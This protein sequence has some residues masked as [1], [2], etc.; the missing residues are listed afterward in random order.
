MIRE[1]SVKPKAS[2]DKAKRAFVFC[3]IAAALC[4][5]LSVFIDLYHGVVSLV[6]MAFLVGGVTIYT[7]YLAVVFIYEITFDSEGTPLFVV[8]QTIGKRHTTL[9]RIGLNEIIRVEKQDRKTRKAHTTPGGFRKYVY[10]PSLDPDTI[11][12]LKTVSRYEKS[13][14][15]IEVSD[16]YASLIERYAAEARELHESIEDLEEY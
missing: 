4:I 12:R 15:L 16:E 10:L 5:A 13:E 6:G 2:N 7:K 9:C 3:M 11:Y 14:I 1:F 8:S